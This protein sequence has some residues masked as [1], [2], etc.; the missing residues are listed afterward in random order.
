[1][2]EFNELLVEVRKASNYPHPKDF[3]SRLPINYRTYRRWETGELLPSDLSFERMLTAC[4]IPSES[5][6]QLQILLNKERA[7]RRGIKLNPSG[8][9]LNLPS[10]AERIER[11]V[12]FELKRLNVTVTPRMR[13]VCTHRIHMIL[14]V[15]LSDVLKG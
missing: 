10:I 9:N 6:H 1:M 7:K 11:E 13:R 5:Y 2:E 3:A 14:S 15:V 12:E 8:A 4:R